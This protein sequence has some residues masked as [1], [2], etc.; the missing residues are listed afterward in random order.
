MATEKKKAGRRRPYRVERRETTIGGGISDAFSEIESLAE[1]MRETFDNM[2][3][4]GLGATDKCQR[5]GEAADAL[6]SISEVE[7]PECLQ[8]VKVAYTELVN[9][10]KGR[11]PSRA[12]R[13]SNALNLLEAC[14]EAAEEADLVEDDADERD[15]FVNEL[16]NAKGE[17]EGVEFPG[18]FG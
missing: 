1:E 7:V 10:R 4:N 15:E 3:G 18:M 16:D 13:L 6:E 9:V 11:G 17:A 12:T 8:D 14:R 5:A 2:D